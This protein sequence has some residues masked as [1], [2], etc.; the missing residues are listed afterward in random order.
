QA[1]PE[2]GALQSAS[3]QL[4]PGKTAGLENLIESLS[5][6]GYE[7]VAQVTTRGQF[8]VR[9]GIVD[10]FSWQSTLPVRIEFFGDDIESLREF[11]IDTQT[12]V[13]DLTNV[14]ILFGNTEEQ[15]GTVRDYIRRDDWIVEIEPEEK[16]SN[17]R[18]II[19][20]GWIEEGP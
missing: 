6:A 10:L 20:E 1:A 19:S 9:G 18:I 7:R 16:E 3:L 8:A 5:R 4:A 12:S 13:R 17:A 2:T 11:D 15:K 14:E